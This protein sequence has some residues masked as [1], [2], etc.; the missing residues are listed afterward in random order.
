M[1]HDELLS[2]KVTEPKNFGAIVEAKLNVH[3]T[4]RKLIRSPFRCD[5]E[6]WYDED[7]ND[8]VWSDL[9]KPIISEKE[10]AIKKLEAELAELK[11][12]VSKG[13]E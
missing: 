9:I 8:Y 3:W 1:T 11:S 7:G 12:Q 6:L 2:P 4:P 10:I 5:T 13:V